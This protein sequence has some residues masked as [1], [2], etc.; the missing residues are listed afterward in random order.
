MANRTKRGSTFAEVSVSELLAGDCS[1]L[2][3]DC[4]GLIKKSIDRMPWRLYVHQPYL[5]S[6][7]YSIMFPFPG[8]FPIQASGQGRLC[9]EMLPTLWCLSNPVSLGMS[10]IPDHGLG[11]SR[12]Q[13]VYAAIEDAA[14]LGII[15]S[16]DF[17]YATDVKKG[18]GMY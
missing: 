16:K 10:I 2:D 12:S 5:V 18:L 3:P 9:R 8:S 13:G 6:S 17:G 7:R 15:F 11:P 14:A 1:S 4:V